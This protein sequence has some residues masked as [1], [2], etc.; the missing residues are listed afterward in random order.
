MKSEKEVLEALKTLQEVCEESNGKC[1]N[2]L[3]RNSSDDCGII[4]NS[5]GDCHDKL[6]EWNLKQYDK[7]RLILN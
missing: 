2:C 7:P 1:S 3:L 4:V 6:T 5:M